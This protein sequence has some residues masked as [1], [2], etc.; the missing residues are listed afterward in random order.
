VQDVMSAFRRALRKGIAAILR[1]FATTSVRATAQA[2]RRPSRWWGRRR[3]EIGSG[4]VDSV[5]QA[6]GIEDR[7]HLVKQLLD[8]KRDLDSLLDVAA[9]SAGLGRLPFAT[10]HALLRSEVER[11][12]SNLMALFGAFRSSMERA[13]SNL[14]PQF[15]QA[16]QD[17]H[18]IG[19]DRPRDAQELDHI[20]ATFAAL[21]F[22]NKALWLLKATR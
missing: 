7:V 8:V 21:V 16:A 1:I 13:G 15:V 17:A 18:R 9:L 10:T 6:R 4:S 11:K 22:R 19:P 20:D 3:F 2:P 14:G 5:H 12:T